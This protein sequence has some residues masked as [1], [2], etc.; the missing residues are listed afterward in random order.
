MAKLDTMVGPELRKSRHTGASEQLSP[1]GQLPSI[2]INESVP[3]IPCD[4]T[5]GESVT[6]GVLALQGDFAE[7]VH[8]LERCQAKTRLVR[9]A[10]DLEGIDG[11]VIPGGESTTI[12]KLT[13]NASD[14]L[15]EDIIAKSRE[16]MPIYGTCMGMIFL[17]RDIEGSSQGRLAL[18]D[19]KVRRNAFGPQI[20][21]REQ[22]LQINELGDDPFH[23]VFIRGPI[24][25]ECADHLN[26]FAR[27][28]EGIVM[29]RQENLLA[30]AFHPEI[31]E[32]D[33]VHRYFVAMVREYAT[34]RITAR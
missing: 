27:V 30:T 13:G 17:A 11:L 26:V 15:F 34:S 8:M 33:R 31:T 10:S 23:I 22:F 24:I 7:H 21:S 3:V 25:L 6:I 4:T 29:C 2:S 28:E 16:G 5:C 9:R 32:D 19:I 14:S 12:A 1:D 20:A 18:M